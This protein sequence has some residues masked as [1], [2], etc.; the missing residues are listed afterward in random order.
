MEE[1]A[2]TEVTAD[3][4]VRGRTDAPVTVLEY[5]D[6]EC[7]Y[8]RGAARTCARCWPAI[9]IAFDSCSGTSP[10]PSA[11]ARGAGGRGGRGGRG[12]G[13]FWEMYER[14][15]QPSSHLELDSL[16]DGAAG[17]GL[18]VGR[19]RDEVTGHAYAARSTGRPAGHPGRASTPRQFYV[20]GERIDGKLPFEGLR[21][22]SGPRCGPPRRADRPG[23]RMYG[24]IRSTV[25]VERHGDGP[26]RPARQNAR[27]RS[28]ARSSCVRGHVTGRASRQRYG[29]RRYLMATALAV[30][31]SRRG[32]KRRADQEHLVVHTV[33]NNSPALQTSSPPMTRE[34]LK[35]LLLEVIQ[36]KSE[37]P[38]DGKLDAQEETDTG[39]IRAL[40]LEF[41]T[42]NEV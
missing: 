7:P 27:H 3:D 37:S 23:Q 20:N 15:L 29:F 25:A 11:S 33:P 26:D 1:F 17:I 32:I 42:V 12:P 13:K 38:E 28:P 14:L 21:T 8:C 6:Y 31:R 22:R 10:S 4:H 36:A 30:S 34:D 16:L 41:K 19:F 18:D 2:V 35:Q 39:I 9:R 40:K 5:G 24:V